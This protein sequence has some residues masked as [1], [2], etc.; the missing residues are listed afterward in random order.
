MR[1]LDAVHGYPKVPRRSPLGGGGNF[2]V[3]CANFGVPCANFGVPCANFGVSCADFGV[4]CA[5]FSV[6][7]AN[8]SPSSS[9]QIGSTTTR[10]PK[11]PPEI[12]P[13]RRLV[14][15]SVVRCGRVSPR[16]RRVSPGVSR[17]SPELAECRPARPNIWCGRVSPSATKSRQ[18]RPSAVECR[19]GRPSVVKCGRVSPGSAE[20]R[21]RRPSVVRDGRVSLETTECCPRRPSVARYIRPSVAEMAEW[22][23]DDPSAC[24]QPLGGQTTRVN[25]HVSMFRAEMDGRFTKGSVRLHPRDRVSPE[26]AECRPGSA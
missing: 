24:G 19:Q 21:P 16:V 4:P 23:P 15:P 1:I 7:C 22:H 9:N 26:S 20:C 10:R 14:R 6:P 2:G 18:V 3:S 8:S 11:T 5:D 25:D 13:E 12:N 17:A